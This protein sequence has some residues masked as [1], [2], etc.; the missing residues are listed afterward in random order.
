MYPLQSQT[1]LTSHCLG[2]TCWLAVSED[3][4]GALDPDA[5]ILALAS[6][7]WDLSRVTTCL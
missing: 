1:S 3:F 4:A 6:P 5:G 2:H 7:L